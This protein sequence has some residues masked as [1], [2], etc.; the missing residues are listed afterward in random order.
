MSFVSGFGQTFFIAVYAGVIR[1]EF[2]VSHGEWGGYYAAGTLASAA[3]MLFVGGLADSISAQKIT[4]V[5]MVAFILV[6]LA[7]AGLPGA[8]ALPFVIFGLRFCGQGMMSHLSV[9]NVSRWFAQDRG[10]AVATAS[11]G[12]SIAE[13]TLPFIFVSIML[14]WGWRVSWAAAALVIALVIVLMRRLLANAPGVGE[15]ATEA[16][17]TA[18]MTTAAPQRAGMCGKHWTRRMM[19]SHWVFW[20]ALFAFLV[21]PAASTVFFFQL[22]HLAEVKGWELRQLTA[23][24]PLYTAA[25]FCA[26]FVASLLADKFGAS[27]LLPFYLL[28]LVAGFILMAVAQTLAAAAAALILIGLMQG[29]GVIMGGLFWPEYYGSKHL[30][31]IRSVAAA[32]TVFASAIGPLASGVLLDNAFTYE[33]QLMA[34]AGMA[35]AACAVFAVI[36]KFS[37]RTRQ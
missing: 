31:A 20:L 23:L 36:E 27:R 25:T 9:V 10:K 5:I 18:A 15:A 8:W 30:G 26:L 19:L 12:F 17:P 7:M 11:V 32:C 33:S 21:H 35:T 22:V 4:L 37:S 24:L 28:P 34:M 16:P 14:A 29:A 13:A 3:L 6:C 1:G 2:N